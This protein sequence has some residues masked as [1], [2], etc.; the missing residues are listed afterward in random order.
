MRFKYLAFWAVLLGSVAMAFGQNTSD[1]RLQAHLLARKNMQVTHGTGVIAGHVKI[2]AT[3]SATGVSMSM[4][5]FVVAYSDSATQPPVKVSADVQPDGSYRLESVPAGTYHVWAWVDGMPSGLYYDQAASEAGATPVEVANG[6]VVDGIDFTFDAKPEGNGEIA[7]RVLTSKGRVPSGAVVVAYATDGRQY[8]KSEVNAD[9]FY[10]LAGL[11]A[12]WYYVQVIANG[13]REVW[14][15]G[16]FNMYEATPVEVVDGQAQNGIDFSL[17]NGSSISG[18]VRDSRGKPVPN[19]QIWI[20]FSDQGI[21]FAQ[22]VVTDE[23]GRY[24]VSGLSGGSYYVSAT[25]PGSYNVFWYPGVP[26]MKD[27]LTIKLQSDSSVENA[28]IKLP[29]S[30]GFGALW[31]TVTD[32]D[33]QLYSGNAYITLSPLEPDSNGTITNDIKPYP[34][35]SY[36][37]NVQNGQ[38]ELDN[39]R[40]GA[41]RMMLSIYTANGASLSFWYP[42]ASNWE[43]ATVLEVKEDEKLGP[44]EFQLPKMDGV[45]KGSVLDGQGK[46]VVGGYVYLTSKNQAWGRYFYAQ[47]QTDGSFL[48]ADLPDDEYIVA[49]YGC[50][51]WSCAY[52]WYPAATSSED[53]TTVV[54]K[55]GKADQDHVQMVLPIEAGQSVLAGKVVNQSG[56][57]LENASVMLMN[58]A[59]NGVYTY[60]Y[61]TTDASGA[62]RIEK[63][64]KGSYHVMYAWYGGDNLMDNRW[65]ENATTKEEATA[66]LLGSNEK[67]E[68]LTLKLDPRPIY[69]AVYGSITDG[70]GQPVANAYVELRPAGGM[71]T[72]MPIY[73]FAHYYVRTD[74]SGQFVFDYVFRGRYTLAAYGDGITVFSGNS[75]REENAVA[76]DVVG[77]EKTQL[78]LQGAQLN[79]TG[80]GVI[81]G[82]VT[83]TM[84]YALDVAIVQ[85]TNLKTQEVYTTLTQSD[86]QYSLKGLPEGDYVAAAFAPYHM[87]Q[88]YDQTWDLMQAKVL[89]IASGNEQYPMVDFNLQGLYYLM[90][91]DSMGPAV[92]NGS[93]SAKS[94]VVQ[95]VVR[96]EKAAPIANALVYA[97]NDKGEPIEYVR[98]G[99]DG[100]YAFTTLNNGAAYRF[101]ASKTGYKSQY[102]DGKTTLS[103]NAPATLNG[104]QQVF[105]FVLSTDAIVD[106]E[107][108]VPSTLKIEGM[109]PNPFRHTAVLRF[110]L[111]QAQDVSVRIY[112][113]L[114][115]QVITLAN[116]PFSSGQHEVVW[117]PNGLP[118]GVYFYQVT[119]KDQ[120]ASGKIMLAR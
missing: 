73:R 14:Y 37:V 38:F 11:S 46:P 44:L 72:Q 31:G 62:Y 78:N 47:T 81:S 76:F 89:S 32:A 96:D 103:E 12:N 2:P 26:E 85:V 74:A 5:A 51:T 118:N 20:Q 15:P 83:T 29:F 97:L 63:L 7:G 43:Q 109:Y 67:R 86:G 90:M 101:Y 112:D 13:Y 28:D 1:L 116:A 45:I 19:A 119:T 34:T 25:V 52:L 49:A 115:R 9:G 50:V 100:G 8:A 22:N 91:E 113:T 57:P 17:E 36:W 92:K 65:F 42:N 48:I 53:A 104:N 60:A 105:D 27:A 68:N 99:K 40:A 30:V 87:I 33:H 75:T 110:S 114:G 56:Q 111:E 79:T 95:G 98:T 71:S 107:E 35:S 23:A 66:I 41:Y 77:G 10:Q 106:V 6:A 94:T 88:Y 16:V 84:G 24:T 93:D 18:A 3:V 120:K 61:A 64:P 55:D 21:Y 82:K 80:A 69:G 70:N 108:E 39:V 59:E 58:A 102:Q 117:T 54:V 4:R